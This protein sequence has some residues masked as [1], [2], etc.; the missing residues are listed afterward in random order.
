M[1]N[2]KPDPFDQPIKENRMLHPEKMHHGMT[3]ETMRILD[4]VWAE[5]DRL[6]EEEEKTRSNYKP[7]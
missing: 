5:S 7:T 4:E 6:D 3:L 1:E 2:P